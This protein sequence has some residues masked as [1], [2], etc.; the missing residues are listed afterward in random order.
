M[1]SVEQI[2]MQRTCTVLLIYFLKNVLADSQPPSEKEEMQ[3]STTERQQKS[4]GY[5]ETEF[6]VLFSEVTPVK[7]KKSISNLVQV[8]GKDRVGFMSRFSLFNEPD[9][10]VSFGSPNAP[11]FPHIYKDTNKFTKSNSPEKY[12]WKLVSKPIQTDEENSVSDLVLTT[13]DANV[14]VNG[15]LAHHTFHSNNA[16]NETDAIEEATLN[17]EDISE[18]S[19]K[20]E[21]LESIQPKPSLVYRWKL[22]SNE[23]ENTY[24]PYAYSH[25]T[26]VNNVETNNHILKDSI[27]GDNLAFLSNPKVTYEDIMVDYSKGDRDNFIDDIEGHPE[28]PVSFQFNSPEIPDVMEPAFRESPNIESEGILEGEDD[29]I[30]S[31]VYLSPSLINSELPRQVVAV[32]PKSISV[33]FNGSSDSSELPYQIIDTQQLVEMLH[34]ERKPVFNSHTKEKQKQTKK[35]PWAKLLG[36]VRKPN[37]YTKYSNKIGMINSYSRH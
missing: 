25:V 9:S 6:P 21:E 8:K 35:S 1:G 18:S 17:A 24:N 13:T 29:K 27:Y 26:N 19:E 14:D 11:G 20:S 23:E 2:T 33:A 22:I 4:I 30:E 15:D 36:I 7:I 5:I 10:F 16:T 31:S 3:N 32:E 28:E 37:Y 12:K 34:Q